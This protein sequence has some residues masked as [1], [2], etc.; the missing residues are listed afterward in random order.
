MQEQGPCPQRSGSNG[1]P[2][3]TVVKSHWQNS[4]GKSED[5]SSLSFN[6]GLIVS[7]Q[8]TQDD[9]CLFIEVD[10][11]CHFVKKILALGSERF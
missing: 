6:D 9:D 5:V 2:R 4:L 3:S 7:S 10:K 11:F 8:L 1:T